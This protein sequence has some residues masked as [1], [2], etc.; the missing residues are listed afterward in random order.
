M[1]LTCCSL[2]REDSALE[3]VLKRSRALLSKIKVV[4][5]GCAA[6]YCCSTF[7]PIWLVVLVVD[8]VVDTVLS[9]VGGHRMIDLSEKMRLFG[10]D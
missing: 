6:E 7:L 10:A 8:L 2:P 1:P 4:Y 3:L 5:S 9:R